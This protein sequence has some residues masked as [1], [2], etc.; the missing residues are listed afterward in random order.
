MIGIKTSIDV[1]ILK[2]NIAAV[3]NIYMAGEVDRP[4]QSSVPGRPTATHTTGRGAHATSPLS[5]C[6]PRPRALRVRAPPVRRRGGPPA[7]PP[8]SAAMQDDFL[9]RR[10][11]RTPVALE[12]SFR[13]DPGSVPPRGRRS[14][15]RWIPAS[16]APSSP[17]CTAR[18]GRRGPHRGVLRAV[19]RGELAD[20]RGPSRLL[21]LVTRTRS[22]GRHM[23]LD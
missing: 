1:H 20:H 7:A 16:R 18:A 14:C 8:P 9:S 19:R 3:R 22:A 11:R 4:T 5:S 12:D 2:R 23:G 17:R 6:R 10:P 13:A 21:L 15:G